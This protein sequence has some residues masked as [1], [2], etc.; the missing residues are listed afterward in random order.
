MKTKYMEITQVMNCTLSIQQL[1]EVF[2]EDLEMQ[3][4]GT[5]HV[6]ELTNKL[7]EVEIDQRKF[8]HKME[9]TQGDFLNEVKVDLARAIYGI[10]VHE[11]MIESEIEELERIQNLTNSA[12]KN[13][14]LLIKSTQAENNKTFK[15]LLSSAETLSESVE[16]LNKQMSNLK[17]LKVLPGD[18]G[19]IEILRVEIEEKIKDAVKKL[20]EKCEKMFEFQNGE[21]NKYMQ[22]FENFNAVLDESID[23]VAKNFDEKLDLKQTAI[24]RIETEAK[25]QATDLTQ[26]LEAEVKRSEASLQDAKTS[27]GQQIGAMR[28]ETKMKHEAL[29]AESKT[30]EASLTEAKTSFGQQIEAMREETKMKHEAL[31]AESKTIEASLTEAKTSFKE[32][33]AKF[34]EI[35]DIFHWNEM[36]TTFDKI[37]NK[38]DEILTREKN[39]IEM[40]ENEETREGKLTDLETKIN[41]VTETLKNS[42]GAGD[43]EKKFQEMKDSLEYSIIKKIAALE[44]KLSLQIATE[45]QQKVKTEMEQKVKTEIEQ[46]VKTEIADY[47][48]ENPELMA[49]HQ[50][51]VTKIESLDERYRLMNDRLEKASTTLNLLG[52]KPLAKLREELRQEMKDL[53]I[54]DDKLGQEIKDLEIKDDKIETKLINFETKLTEIEISVMDLEKQKLDP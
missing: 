1:L 12:Q 49:V 30:I 2:Q 33:L 36:K 7:K 11:A 29:E 51:T 46:K 34:E 44:V 14:L 31:E 41:T 25:T 9:S 19:K 4:K 15:M 39:I 8:E 5:Q 10:Q 23:T 3:G 54:K 47:I 26:A 43:V 50:S 6:I 45:M 42:I 37:E 38:Y 35:F 20:D 27:F 17:E 13:L 40:S 22:D 18:T 32:D 28:E 53:G 24:E 21:V 16:E 52:E 48:K